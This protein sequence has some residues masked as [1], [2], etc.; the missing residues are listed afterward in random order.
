MKAE[1]GSKN[2]RRYDAEFKAN[3]LR[4][5]ANGRSVSS[6]SQAMGISEGLLY[7][8]KSQAKKADQKEGTSESEEVKA[9]R[10][11]V[12]ELEQERD[13]LKKAL[14]IFSRQT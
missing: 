4:M 13:I 9:L 12:K 11:R 5:I 2:R 6:V 8:W 10:K 14:S 7:R 1:K 3:I